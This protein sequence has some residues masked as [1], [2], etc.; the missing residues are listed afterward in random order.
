MGGCFMK[1]IIQQFI[2]KVIS[3]KE[4]SFKDLNNV[5]FL[6]DF[7]DNLNMNLMELGRELVLE[8]INELETLI[9]NSKE[10]KEKFTSYQ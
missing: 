5:N 8:Y 10:R 7:T 1:D 6:S 9:Y 2:E 4:R 3:L